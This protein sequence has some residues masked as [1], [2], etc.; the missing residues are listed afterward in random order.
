MD[1]TGQAVVIVGGPGDIGSATARRF[2]DAGASVV[3]T[4]RTS[5]SVSRRTAELGASGEAVDP[6]DAAV[7][8][9]FFARIGSFDHL[10]VT[11]GT[12]AITT[13]FEALPE[14]QIVRAIEDKLLT[15][16]RTLRAALPYVTQSVTWLTAA[17]A[18]TSLAGMSGYAAPN[19][20][21][22]AMLGPI[23]MEITPVRI[24][25]VSPGLARTAFWDGLGMSRQEQDAM[26][27]GAAQTIPLRRVGSAEDVAQAMLF[28]AT[29]PY[30]TGAIF[31]ISGGLQLGPLPASDAA[32]SYGDR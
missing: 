23:A 27:A 25:C 22:H 20:A 12:Q 29:N 17:A 16:T 19:G 10:A 2:L 24:N 8:E 30:V 13:V 18:R 14:E 15:Y 1:L 28:A 6:H 31:D 26:F 3:L 9:A 32:V 4:G 7:L 11:L 21:L 5:A